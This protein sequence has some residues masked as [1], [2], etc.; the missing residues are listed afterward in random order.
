MEQARI[1][2]AESGLR[3]RGRL[4]EAGSP[5]RPAFTL[6]YDV[7]VDDEG[8]ARE[9]VLESEG[10]EASR[11]LTLRYDDGESWLAQTADGESERIDTPGGSDVLISGSMAFFSLA[12]RANGLHRAPDEISRTA[13]SVDACGLAV[14]DTP[15]SFRSDDAMVHGITGEAATSAHVDAE[16]FVLDVPGSIERR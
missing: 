5:E 1:A 10:A 15:M 4:I 3:V 9:I 6:T 2:P 8:Q 11:S 13:V 14:S 7:E 16:G 12:V